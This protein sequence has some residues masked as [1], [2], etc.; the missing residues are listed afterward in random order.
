MNGEEGDGWCAATSRRNNDWLQIDFGDIY[1]VCAVA[2]QGDVD[3]N[4]WVTA[5]RLFFSLNGKIW[6]LYRDKRNIAVVRIS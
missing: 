3:G 6:N 4:E 2:T 1:V 5:F